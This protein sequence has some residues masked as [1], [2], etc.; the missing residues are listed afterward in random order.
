MTELRED[1]A[2]NTPP[3]DREREKRVA[4]DTAASLVEDGMRVGLGS[5]ST[6]AWLLQAL[7]SRSSS[8]HCFA[9]SPATEQSARELGLHVESFA[10]VEAPRRLDIAIDG[11]DQ[12]TPS[13]WLVKGR[14][15]AHTREK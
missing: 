8:L 2:V 3:A 1:V 6:V 4:A 10:G 7:A 15:G 13:G 9:S 5:G 12:V 14:G 11:A